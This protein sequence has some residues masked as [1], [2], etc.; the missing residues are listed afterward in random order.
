MGS[1]TR[2]ELEA[3]GWYERIGAHGAALR[4][5]LGEARP[6]SRPAMFHC[7][8]VF[9]GAVVEDLAGHYAEAHTEGHEHPCQDCGTS[10]THLFPLCTVPLAAIQC[11]DCARDDAGED[12]PR[13]FEHNPA[14]DLAPDRD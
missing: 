12:R 4:I 6:A 5:L 3:V 14:L 10:W 13:I 11:G 9:C 2:E 8:E 1:G 7:Q